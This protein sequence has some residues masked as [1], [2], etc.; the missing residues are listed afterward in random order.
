MKKETWKPV[1]I[2][3]FTGILMGAASAY[4]MQTVMNGEQSAPEQGTKTVDYDSLSF[5]DAFEAARSEMGPGGVFTWHG[6]VYN[7]YTAAEWNAKTH[8]E[9]EKFAEQV[10]PQLASTPTEHA[11][12]EDDV[13]VVV[14][15][16]VTNEL[17]EKPEEQT[18]GDDNTPKEDDVRILGYGDVQLA[19]GEIVTVEDIELN[20]QR[21]RIIDLDHDGVGDV[22]MSDLNNNQ[23]ADDGEVIDLHTGETLSFTNDLDDSA[24]ALTTIEI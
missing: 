10:E 2:S 24:D 3:G 12:T 14:Q 23:Q 18:T 1:T 17:E 9:Q 11:G 21:V 13:R 7:T 15:N 5:K 8:Q 22:A 19:N 6:N 20:R 4:G 16:N